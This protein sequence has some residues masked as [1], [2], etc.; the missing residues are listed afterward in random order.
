M[1]RLWLNFLFRVHTP[2]NRVV[3]FLQFSPFHKIYLFVLD[4]SKLISFSLS[5]KQPR[6]PTICQ[7]RTSIEYTNVEITLFPRFS[8]LLCFLF[9]FI[10]CLG[11]VAIKVNKKLPSGAPK[12]E[13]NGEINT[14]VEKPKKKYIKAV[15]SAQG[16]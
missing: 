10:S 2:H 6:F 1:R 14:R 12:I 4:L 5:T 15:V 11:F 13:T 7:H 8:H 3:P 9:F 16:K